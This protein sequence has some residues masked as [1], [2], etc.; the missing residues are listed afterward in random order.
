MHNKDQNCKYIH[1]GSIQ[2]WIV[3]LHYFDKDIDLYALVYDP[4]HNKFN[5]EI[6]LWI[7][8]NLC[9]HSVGFNCLPRYYVSLNEEFAKN[10]LSLKIKVVGME[11]KRGG[12]W[13]R[14]FWKIISKLHN[15]RYL[16]TKVTI[17]G[18][19]KFKCSTLMQKIQRIKSNI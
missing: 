5:N 8:T 2:V 10:F 15:I 3:P 9:N 16:E 4:R 13:L 14:M 11:M 7:K 18:V 6:I 12:H 17:I 1:I 19:E